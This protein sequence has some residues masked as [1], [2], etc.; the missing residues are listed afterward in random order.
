MADKRT[1]EERLTT[2]G[3]AVIFVYAMCLLFYIIGVYHH[4]VLVERIETLE[5]IRGISQ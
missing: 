2:T 3:Y 5:T 1:V 4:T